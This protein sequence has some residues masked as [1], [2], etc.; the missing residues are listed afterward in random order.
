MQ[1]RFL[2]LGIVVI[3]SIALGVGIVAKQARNSALNIVLAQQSQILQSQKRIAQKVGADLGGPG[4]VSTTESAG[5]RKELDDLRDR[6][7]KV[8]TALKGLQ[9]GAALAPSR[10]SPPPGFPQE[11]YSQVYSIDIGHSPVL[12]NKDAAV[13]VVEF[14]DFQCPYSKKFHP[15]LLE[16]LKAFPPEKVNYVLKQFPLSFHPAALP[17]AKAAFAAGE[18]GKYWEMVEALFKAD[19]LSEDKIQEAAKGIGLNMKK[20]EKDYEGKDEVWEQYI[21][22]DKSL[23]RQ[24]SVRGTPTFFIGGRKTQARDTGGFKQEIEKALEEKDSGK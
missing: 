6:L 9:Q 8:E 20:F 2:I 10:V 22:A 7:G 24:V 16:A 3:L 19:R 12:G 14:S 23:A 13:T 17:A 11:D 1:K 18:Q 5:M 4:E 15:E 21:Q